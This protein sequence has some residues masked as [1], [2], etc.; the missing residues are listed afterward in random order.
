MIAGEL[1]A[2]VALG[3]NF[4]RAA[5]DQPR[6]EAAWRQ[7]P[8][9]ADCTAFSKRSEKGALLVRS[10]RARQVPLNSGLPG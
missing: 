10:T 8:L 4:I 3:G 7:L 5:P 2:F 1:K 9:T 6:V